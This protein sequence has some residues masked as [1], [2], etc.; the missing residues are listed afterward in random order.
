MAAGAEAAGS[1]CFVLNMPRGRTVTLWVE[2][3]LQR[4]LQLFSFSQG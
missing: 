4:V 3:V 1:D 2:C